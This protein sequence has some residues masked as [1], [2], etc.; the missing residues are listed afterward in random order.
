MNIHEAVLE[1]VI[2]DYEVATHRVR[3]LEEKLRCVRKQRDEM[4]KLAEEMSAYYY[5]GSNWVDRFIAI[6]EEI[7]KEKNE[8]GKR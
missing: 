4:Q 7:N 3:E 8:P 1:R 2:R 6:T 5:A